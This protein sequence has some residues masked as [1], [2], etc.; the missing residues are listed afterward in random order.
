[1][2]ARLSLYSF[3]LSLLSRMRFFFD[4]FSSGRS[5]FFFIVV[6]LN[7]R[8][9]F[10]SLEERFSKGKYLFSKHLETVERFSFRWTFEGNWVIRAKLSRELLDNL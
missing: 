8:R 10:F 5:F 2:V 9:G 7:R 3:F 1:M 6:I 4:N